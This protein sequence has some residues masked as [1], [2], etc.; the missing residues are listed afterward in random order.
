VYTFI[1]SPYRAFVDGVSLDY[2]T[3]FW[4]LPAPFNGLVFGINYTHM[5]SKA[6]YPLMTTKDIVNPAHPKVATTVIVDST[7]TGR[8][9]DQ[10]ND[11]M[12]AY[13]GYDYE[14]FSARLS[15]LFQ[16]N[17][18]SYVGNYPE[19]DGFTRN[20]FRIDAQVRQ[21]LPWKGFQIFFDAE[22]LNNE[23][24]ISAQNSI[25]GITSEQYYGLTADL[26]IRYIL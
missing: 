4:Y 17:S 9:V 11:I 7:R 25:G 15:F 12:N 20:Y 19:Q 18:V 13:V 23:A 26:G 14:G 24:N 6:T 22:N 21:M 10:P 8:L 16:G 1:N 5:T 2:Q 3:N